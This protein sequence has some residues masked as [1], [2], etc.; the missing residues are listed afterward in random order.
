MN[1]FAKLSPAYLGIL[2]ALIG[3]IV[4]GSHTPAERGVLANG[5]NVA[6]I[7]VVTTWARAVFL[8]IFCRVT[9]RSLYQCRDDFKQALIGGACQVLSALSI[10]M[11]LLYLPAPVVITIVYSYAL[12]LLFFM[13][14][15]R[16]ITLDVVTVLTAVTA[17]GGL[18]LVIDFWHY[19]S[20]ANWRGIGLSLLSALA[21]VSRMYV[22]GKQTQ[23]RNPAVVGAES[24][25]IAAPLATLILFVSP[26]H[27]P[28]VA[29]GYLW[30]CVASA[31][32]AIGSFCM[33]F[34]ISL[35]GSF[36]YSLF[37]KME[38]VF[39]CLFS[40]WFLN[41]VLK[42]QQYMGIVVVV[43]SLV[44]YQMSEHRRVKRT[45]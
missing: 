38:P 31:S 39:T 45:A 23:S 16:E 33:F 29:V 41:E 3:A 43:G 30:L 12:M 40:V 4:F 18:S 35:L 32:L 7:L 44:L 11:A 37:A 25:L 26:M 13:A 34:G 24:F 20:S 15:R 9:S 36:R 8:A 10:F 28:E 6:L 42:P 2:V 21:T 27:L 14:L 17:L 5:G 19:Q 1:F 22:Y